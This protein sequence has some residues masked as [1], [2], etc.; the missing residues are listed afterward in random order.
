MSKMCVLDDTLYFIGKELWLKFF[1][2][3]TKLVN[4][5]WKT[6]FSVLFSI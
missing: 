5:A 1:V 4:I 2:L 3:F 6:N